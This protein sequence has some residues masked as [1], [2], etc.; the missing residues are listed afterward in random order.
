M[1]TLYVCKY[2]TIFMSI[3]EIKFVAR[4]WVT[5]QKFSNKTIKK[6]TC[7]VLRLESRTSR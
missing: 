6:R 4:T 1:I 5:E 7:Y 3:V 2:V